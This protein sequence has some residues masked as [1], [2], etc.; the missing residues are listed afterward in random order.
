MDTHDKLERAK[1]GDIPLL[2]ELTREAIRKSDDSLAD[3]TYKAAFAA[4]DKILT[5]SSQM[6]DLLQVLQF[7]EYNVWHSGHPRGENLTEEEK[8][9]HAEMIGEELSKMLSK[10]SAK[11]AF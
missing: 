3:L 10:M 8:V 1:G 5:E 7:M 9:E 11:L 6:Q 2:W 4:W